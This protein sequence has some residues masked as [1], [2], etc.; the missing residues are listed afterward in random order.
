MT[1][2][3]KCEYCKIN[4]SSKSVLETHIKRKHTHQKDFKCDE[5]TEDFYTKADL[6]VH[7]LK[8]H[9]DDTNAL[10][11][12]VDG[13]TKLF[14]NE[15]HLVKHFKTHEKKNEILYVCEV[16]QKVY[17]NYDVYKS[18]KSEHKEPVV[19]KCTY[20]DCDKQ[21]NR[22]NSLQQH[23]ITQH[24]KEYPYTCL[25]KDCN[26]KFAAKID[27]KVHTD[28]YHTLNKTYKCEYEKCDYS[29]YSCSE[30]K[31][32]VNRIHLQLKYKCTHCTEILSS[33]ESLL[34]HTR[35]KH[36]KIY[37]H[38]CTYEKCTAK[39]FTSKELSAHI[40]RH[41]TFERTEACDL[42]PLK[43]YAKK[44]LKR[45]KNDIHFK[46]EYYKCEKCPMSFKRKER[47]TNHI[48]YHHTE[49][50]IQIQKKKEHEIAKL[51]DLHNIDYKREHHID[52][53]CINNND[54]FCRI[55]FV[56]IRNGVIIFLEVDEQQ[57][58]W[59]PMSCETR[60]MAQIFQTLMIENNT[61]PIVFLRYNPDTFY[62]D[63]KKSKILKQERHKIL[64]EEIEK[65]SAFT[66]N[67][68]KY[69]FY[70]T[71]ENKLSLLN[72]SEYLPDILPL[73]I[74]G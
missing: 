48:T 71:D 16:C 5:C 11:C 1:D 21:Y 18:H 32:H 28:R 37:T 46:I 12:I 61:M 38:M 29:S 19:Y 39:F 6:N 10:H 66:K 50:G 24:T 52:F 3:Y 43:F 60:R 30:L 54:T 62:I 73:V 13:C 65:C 7:K 34:E 20:E 47:L 22:S 27:L 72:D 35:R 59:Y 33:P 4:Y 26:K 56:I 64:L 69:L 8:E 9:I 42:C 15:S 25:E 14:Y 44:D 53:K 41:H 2:K 45:H 49:K 68:I 70:D 40:K 17:S 67:T 36:T 31:Q 74:Q 23:I 51:L 58:T 55:D 63:G 57:H